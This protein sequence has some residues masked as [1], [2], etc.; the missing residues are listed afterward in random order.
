MCAQINLQS[1]HQSMQIEN[2]AL[3]RIQNVSSV[4]V[5]IINVHRHTISSTPN[6]TDENIQITLIQL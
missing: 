1:I 5:M 4:I 2:K 3:S 6:N